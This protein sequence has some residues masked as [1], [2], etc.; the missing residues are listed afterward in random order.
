M[1]HVKRVELSHFKSFGGTTKIPFL[2]GFTVIS[3][4][5]GSGKSNILDA[6]LFCLG[7]ASS[8]GMRAER[9][10]DLVNHKYSNS[11]RGAETIVSVTFDI[12]DL[13]SVDR[14]LLKEED[15]PETTDSQ[16]LTGEDWT[17]TRRLRVTKGGNYS[18]TFYING[19]PSTATELHEQLNRLRIYPE[20]YNVVLQGDVTRIITMNS[21]ERRE[22]IDELAGVAEFD[23]KIEQTKKTLDAVREREERCRIIEQELIKTRDRLAADSVKAEKYQKLKEKIQEKQQWEI[24]LV[25]RSQKQK[26]ASLEAEITAGETQQTQLTEQLNALDT[27]INEATLEF[28]Q[29]NSQIKALGEEEQLSVASQ[30]ATQKAKRHQLQQK[31]E[32]LKTSFQQTETSIDRAKKEIEQYQNN[33]TQLARDKSRLE[34][35]TIPDRSDECQQG[36]ETL[37][38]TKEQAEAIAAASE[39]WVQQQTALSHKISDLQKTLNP[40][41]TERAQLTERFN[42]LESKIVEETQLLTATEAEIA[43]KQQEIDRLSDRISTSEQQIQSVADKLGTSEQELL[44]SEE[45]RKRLASEQREKQRQLDKLEAASQAQQEAQGTYATKVILNANLSGVCGLVVQLGQV[46]PPYQLALETAAGG[47]LGH[48]VVEDDRVA[49]AGIELLKQKRAGRATFLPLNKIQ[50]PHYIETAVLRYAKGFIDLAVNLIDCDPRYRKIFAYVL[51]STVIFQTLDD[52]RPHLGKQRIVTLEGEILEASG[53]MTG[54]SKIN[55]SSLH[56]GT[57]TARE[58]QELEIL[59]RR[60]Q[61]IE[62][63]LERNELIISQQSALVKQLTKEL[64]ESRQQRRE[65]QL[66]LEQLQREIERLTQQKEQLNNQISQNSQELNTAKNR[67][68]ALAVEIPV[69]E[70]ELQEN[71]ESLDALEES[72]THSEWL[73]IQNLIKQQEADLQ[74]RERALRQA[75]EQLKDLVS[76]CQRLEEKITESNQRIEDYRQQKIEISDRQSATSDDLSTIEAKIIETEQLLQQLSEKLGETK[77]ERDR[78]EEKLRELQNQQ[79]KKS[80]KLQ[81]LQE[82]Q[83]ERRENLENLQQQLEEQEKELP[84]PLPEIPNLVAS[85]DEEEAGAITFESFTAQL[86]QLQKE[87]RNSQKRLQAMEPVNMLALEEYDRTQTRLQELSE[88]LTTLEGERTELLLRVEKFTTLRF[89]AFKEAFDAVNENFQNIFASLSDGDGCLQLDHPDNPFNGGLN[90]IAHPKGK[91]VQ[92]LSSMSGGE[93]SL[94]ALS[95]IFA[96]QRYRPSPFYAFDEVDMFLDGANVEK[97]SKMIRKQSEQ[98]Q[99]IVVSLRRPMI[100]SSERTIGVTQARGAHTQVLGIKL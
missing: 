58:S 17:V 10:P 60:L 72:Q 4:P 55:R 43:L 85:G 100:E 50:P 32:E 16:K 91:P 69:L 7:L 97:L 70:K 79:Q 84:E 24:V 57:A 78:A 29:L 46:E 47:R 56:F 15:D 75:E 2:Q 82:T 35:E 14:E 53:A 18:S 61:E 54:G 33:I 28:N 31:Q 25:W 40:Q 81:K 51:G 44:I 67:L 34:T 63:I 1:V 99:F 68:E 93:K 74:K 20:G 83:K 52:A 9:L 48:I 42:Q 39:I 77:K 49:A 3:G 65:Q 90:L 30:L 8:K 95:F 94:T 64:T 21:R 45:T 26:Q 98:A 73:Q 89:Q 6:L 71:Q 11:N 23:R 80:W 19:E 38:E 5:N 12:S 96:L 87:I 37:K 66:C 13:S 22:I 62:Q 27:Q 41:R 92:R 59:R 36:R 76:N 88:K 86:E